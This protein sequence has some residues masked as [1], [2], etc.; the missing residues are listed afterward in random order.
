MMH[1]AEK[2]EIHYYLANESHSMDA[3]VRNKCEA[4]LLAIFQEVCA[5]LG[6]GISVEA[7][8][9]QEGGLREFWKL[10]GNSQV[11]VNTAL[12]IFSVVLAIANTVLTRFP[13]SDKEKDAR[14]KEI[15]ELTIEEKRLA[16]QEKKIAL[17][18]LKREMKDG[19]PLKETV[20]GAAKATEKS[21]KI[22]F[23]PA[24]K[25]L[26]KSHRCWLHWTRQKQQ[27]Y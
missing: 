9:Q 21:L 3:L 26:R 27:A 7:L 17:E 25:Q 2:F 1:T 5:T 8:A 16:I 14:E 19:Q 10:L 13:V 12:T 18:K 6:V 23:L 11:Q 22:Q 24:L 20:E 15:Q 4:E